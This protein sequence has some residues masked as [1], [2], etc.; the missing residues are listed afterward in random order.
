MVATSL[1]QVAMMG[2]AD[3]VIHHGGNNTVQEA[4]AAGARQLVLPM[5]TDQFAN[6]ADL[7]RTGAAGIAAANDVTAAEI[8]DSIAQL[9]AEPCPQATDSLDQGCLA[10]ALFGCAP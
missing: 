7:E 1:P 9:L 2:A 3:L 10:S 4:L 5:S 6:A 8:A